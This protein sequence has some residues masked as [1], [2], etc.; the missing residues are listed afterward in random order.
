MSILRPATPGFIVTLIATILLAVVSFGVPLL[1]SIYFLKASLA[2]EGISGNITFGTLGYCIE[3]S[4]IST[5]SNATVGYELDINQ[6]V[7]NNLPVQI[8]EVLVKWVTYALVLHIVAFGLAAVSAIFGLLAHVREMSMTCFSSCISGFGAVVALLAFIFDLVFFFVAKS[9][10]NSVQGGSASI[11]NAVWLTLAAW[12]LLFFSGCF[13]TVGRC[14]IRRRSRNDYGNNEGPNN[15]NNGY[16]EQ[17]RLDAV[18]AEADRKQRQQQAEKGLPAFQEYDP[19]QPLK[20]ASAEDMYLEEEDSVPYRDNQSATTAGAAGVGAAGRRQSQSGY[21]GGGYLQAPAGTRAVDEYNNTS[22]PPRPSRQASSH[23]QHTQSASSYYATPAPPAGPYGAPGSRPITAY[24]TTP[25][26]YPQVDPYAAPY[27]HAQAGSSAFSAPPPQPTSYA[28]YDPY[29]TRSPP[30]QQQ[31]YQE[32]S[33]NPD[34]YNTTAAMA[35]P[36]PQQRNSYADP[37]GVQNHQQQPDRGYTVGGSGYGGNTVPPLNEYAQHPQSPQQDNS[38]F[39]QRYASPPAQVASPPGLHTAD[40]GVAPPSNF[41]PTKPRG[42]R[43]SI[44]ASSSSPS[45]DDDL[46]PDYASG[47]VHPPGEWASKGGGFH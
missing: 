37:Y 40:L 42:P 32:P 23:T 7:G 17:L 9:R 41:S 22:Y 36:P 20:R 14:C 3:S 28:I 38:Y 21:A 27:G 15:A 43:T 30:P 11:G 31:H 34:T 39:P 44:I 35:S 4:A 33:F 5:C 6:L 24:S 25:S 47:P 46:P 8:P 45:H 10:L 26:N 2:V 19:A 12:V 1:K 18:K 29:G 16:G 13:Y